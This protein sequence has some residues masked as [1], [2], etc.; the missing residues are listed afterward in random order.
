MGNWRDVIWEAAELTHLRPSWTPDSTFSHAVVLLFSLFHHD[1]FIKS[2]V[3]ANNSSE[4]NSLLEMWDLDFMIDGKSNG[5]FIWK[6]DSW[7]HWR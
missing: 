2:S 4:I 1:L 5:L 3:V 6:K 7:E